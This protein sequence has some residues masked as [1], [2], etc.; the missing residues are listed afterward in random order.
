MKAYYTP[1]NGFIYAVI[2]YKQA[3]DIQLIEESCIP[4]FTNNNEMHLTTDNSW[5]LY[6]EKRLRKPRAVKLYKT[7]EELNRDLEILGFYI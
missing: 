4:G 5:D 1:T 6:Y 7:Q 3:K 2:S